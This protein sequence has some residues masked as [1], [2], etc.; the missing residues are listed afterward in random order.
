MIEN[1]RHFISL[2]LGVAG[3]AMGLTPVP[4]DWEW[5][6]PLAITLWVLALLVFFWAHLS[7][8]LRPTGEDGPQEEAKA[9][10]KKNTVEVSGTNNTVSVGHIGDEQRRRP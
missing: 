4:A 10:T 3:L 8:W 9:A 5:R 2:A 1:K 7:A 6:L